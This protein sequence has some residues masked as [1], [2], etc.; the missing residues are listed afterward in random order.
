MIATT[1]EDIDVS[2]DL[3]ELG[4][5]VGKDYF[6]HLEYTTWA[7]RALSLLK[8]AYSLII[9][10]QPFRRVSKTKVVI[11]MERHLAIGGFRCG[12]LPD[13]GG[14]NGNQKR[15]RKTLHQRQC[16]D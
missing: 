6:I 5:E 12:C 11:N 7:E 9:S 1:H 15:L 4:L 16:A 2:V 13:I 3:S 14:N 8:M 10:G